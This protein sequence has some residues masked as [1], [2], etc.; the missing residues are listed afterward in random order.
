MVIITP[1]KMRRTNPRMIKTP[2]TSP[3]SISLGM[4]KDIALKLFSKL[5]LLPSILSE[6][7]FIA[8]PFGIV[9]IIQHAKAKSMINGITE[10][11][12]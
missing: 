11:K 9:S 8:R 5:M 10:V 3:N 2:L 4:L 6:E 1:G 12:Y 7:Y